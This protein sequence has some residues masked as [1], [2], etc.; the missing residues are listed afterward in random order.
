ME[1]SID[2]VSLVTHASI[3]VKI[4]MGILLFASLL[5]WVTIFRLSSRLA[6]ATRADNYFESLESWKLLSNR[7]TKPAIKRPN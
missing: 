7:A 2:L 4:I 5:C 1:G 3:F 6:I